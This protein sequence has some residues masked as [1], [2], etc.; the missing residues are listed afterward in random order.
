MTVK[1]EE[2]EQAFEFVSSSPDYESAAY[3][4]RSTGEIFYHSETADISELPEDWESHSDDFL[5]IPHKHELDLGKALVWRFVDRE[6][7]E[8]RRTIESLFRRP[9]AYARHQALLASLG[10]LK[11]WYEFEEQ[12]SRRALLIWCQD[13]SLPISHAT[14]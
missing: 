2:L 10:L 1:L 11:Q 4:R 5:E 6:L 8:Q 7:S 12:E 13:M 14:S 3:V 9:G